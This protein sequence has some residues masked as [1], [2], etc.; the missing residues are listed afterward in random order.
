MLEALGN[1]VRSA[2]VLKFRDNAG[3]RCRIR[4][5]DADIVDDAPIFGRC[6]LTTRLLVSNVVRED[7]ENHFWRR[8]H[9]FNAKSRD[10]KFPQTG[11]TMVCIFYRGTT[12]STG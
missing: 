5:G 1:F 9:A 10:G 7:A 6:R 12:Q 8:M 3:V 11:F 4:S 2:C